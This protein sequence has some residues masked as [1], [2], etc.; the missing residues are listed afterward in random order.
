MPSAMSVRRAGSPAGRAIDMAWTPDRGG[1]GRTSRGSGPP[2][3]GSCG[4][5]DHPGRGESPIEIGQNVVDMLDAN[6]EPHITLGDA[7]GVL[8]LRR[9]L[10]MR[11][12]GR[13]DGKT[14][15]IADIGNVVMHLERVDEP[16]TGLHA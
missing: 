1:R 15:G 6:R 2:G 3:G 8:L 13:M 4:G 5:S 7:A 14:P 12:R 16:P 9:E 11:R 10:R